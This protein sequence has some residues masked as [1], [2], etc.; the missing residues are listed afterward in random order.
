[1][2]FASFAVANDLVKDDWWTK[3]REITE[4]SFLKE[5][6]QCVKQGDLLRPGKVR[7]GHWKKSLFVITE[8]GYL[9]CFAYSSSIFSKRSSSSDEVEECPIYDNLLKPETVYR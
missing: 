9:H 8:T 7:K 5:E 3:T 1:M 6:I 4:Y 2:L